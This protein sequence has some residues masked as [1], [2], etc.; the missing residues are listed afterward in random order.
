MLQLEACYHYQKYDI[1]FD[2]FYMNYFAIFKEKEK[3]VFLAN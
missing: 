1:G 2:L 3:N